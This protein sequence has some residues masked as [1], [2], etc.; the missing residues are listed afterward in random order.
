MNLSQQVEW[1]KECQRRGSER[2]YANQDR[3]REKN[4]GDTT[5]VMS[6]LIKDR[7]EDSADYLEDLVKSGSRG[8]AASYNTIIRSVAQDDYLKIAYIGLKAVLKAIQVREKN[9]VLKVTL[10]IAA[11]IEAD[12]KCQMF[13]AAHPEYYD[14]VRRSFAEQ[15]V[16]DYAHK[17]KVLM[18][19]FGDFEI[20]WYDWSPTEKVQIGVRILRAILNVFGDIIFMYTERSR[21]KTT[22][23]LDTTV[24]FDEWAAEFEKERG[25][26]NPTYLPLKVPPRPWTSL[27]EGGY[28]T[29]HLR[30]RFVKT[31]GNDHK[32]F[33]EQ[34]IPH[35]HIRAVNK[36]QRTAWQ[37]NDTVLKVQE[38]I[39]H[40]GL[41]IGM[42]SKE[43][44][45]PP[46]FPEHLKS[47]D[48]DDLTDDQKDEI[49]NWKIIAKRCYGREQQRK[50]Q[51]LAFIQ[52]H[53]LAKEL[54]DWERLYF[55]YTCDFRGRIYCATSGL[56]PQ[57][58]DT[59]KGLLRFAKSV[60]LGKDGVKWLAIHGANT[61]GEDKLTYKDR[62]NWINEH[63]PYIK[64]VVSDPISHRDFWGSADK[65]Y[66]F[67]AFCFEWANCDYGRDHNATGQLPVGL[68]GSCNGLQH[69][70]AMLRDEVGAAATN[71]MPCSTPEDIY[72]QVA[73]VTTEKLKEIDDPRAEKWLKVGVAR[74]CAK[75]PVM[76]L[77]YGATQQSARTYIMEYVM[78][79]WSKFELDESHQWD[80]ARF[81]TPILWESI[82][83][84]VIA[85]REGMD[86]LQKNSG[87]DYAKWLTPLDFPVYQ[88]YKKVDATR[89]VT[90]L[91]GKVEIWLRDFNREGEPAYSK[92]RNGIAPN[93]VHSID[94]TH[95][96]M[97]INGTDVDS[98][99]MIHDDFGTHAG[100]TERLF[101][102]IRKSF[103][104]LY[105]NHNPM[106]EWA[107]QMG[108]DVMTMPKEGSYNIENIEKADF[109]FG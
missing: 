44:I 6:Y 66:Q 13:E 75:R 49:R 50:G 71:L 41:G 51:V 7:L 78:D 76:T 20:E 94:S 31:K 16:T 48:K 79:N 86:W 33:V 12:M 4:Q 100:N 39:Y 60:V 25:L 107:E 106:R 55:A 43:R 46:T 67:L 14:T 59:A 42:P 38:E 87:R 63:E 24:Q 103:L 21:G 58:A 108:V 35:K 27:T 26:L 3:L 91:D 36:M 54:R 84:V 68:D 56:S 11:R 81:L 74:S 5:D 73:D 15:N 8:R 40:K 105:K 90:Q 9:T 17:H 23:K 93:F 82:S 72:Q 18:K 88:Y 80:F 101:K 109:F 28:H 89:V 47:I 70:S 32:E 96:V 37:I 34:H 10:D 92:Q 83:E 97:T 19:K 102:A 95:M 30:L 62:V 2:Y 61:F 65:P 99:A 53:K 45:E 29:P 1:E 57:G 22:N 98:Y 104:I 64:Q 52:G 77:P 69:F 85:A